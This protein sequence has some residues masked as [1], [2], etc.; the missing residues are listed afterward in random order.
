MLE[1]VYR[2]M[3]HHFEEHGTMNCLFE[4]VENLEDKEIKQYLIK[5]YRDYQNAKKKGREIIFSF[6]SEDET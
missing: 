2:Q 3:N 4:A 5:T 6:Q 1:S